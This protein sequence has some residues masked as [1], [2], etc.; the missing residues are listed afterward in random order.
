MGS[1]ERN[2][3]SIIAMMIALFSISL[4]VNVLLKSERHMAPVPKI[5]DELVV[6][7]NSK[8]MISSV[9]ASIHENRSLALYNE[10]GEWVSGSREDHELVMKLDE[11]DIGRSDRFLIISEMP[12]EINS[13]RGYQQNI[14]RIYDKVESDLYFIYNELY[15]EIKQAGLT[16]TLIH[17]ER[18]IDLTE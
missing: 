17:V 3:K 6:A 8:S 13:S 11:L 5:N 4:I 2:Y 9:E 15:S 18:N 7:D 16:S 12:S 1:K 14:V 10:S